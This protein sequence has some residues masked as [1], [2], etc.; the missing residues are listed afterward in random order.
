[1]VPFIV[2]TLLEGQFMKAFVLFVAVGISDGVDGFIARRF[3]QRTE[4][5]AYLDPMADKILLISVFIVLGYLEVLPIWLA[6]AIVTRDVMIAA[7]VLVA[8][9]IGN[10]LEMRPLFVSKANTAAQIV[11]V[12]IAIG[13]PAF[14]LDVAVLQSVM[15]WICGALTITSAFAYF[16][17]WTRHMAG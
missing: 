2:W 11:L 6:I 8:F 7:G 9:I 10:P 14:A 1:M 4:L 17:I 15:V 5:G 16:A 12:S 3:N 13:A